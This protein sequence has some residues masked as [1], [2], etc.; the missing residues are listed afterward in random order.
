M[1]LGRQL[2]SNV[3]MPIPFLVL[4]IADLLWV[5]KETLSPGLVVNDRLL[6]SLVSYRKELQ[7]D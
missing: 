5:E 6:A 2:E 4:D 3:N 7:D 1:F